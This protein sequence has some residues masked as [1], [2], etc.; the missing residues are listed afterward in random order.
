[1]S[2]N[3]EHSWHMMVARHYSADR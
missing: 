3:T 2:A 1:M